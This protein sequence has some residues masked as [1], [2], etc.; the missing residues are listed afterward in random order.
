MSAAP[1]IAVTVASAAAKALSRDRSSSLRELESTTCSSPTALQ[2]RNMRRLP[3]LFRD[4][5]ASVSGIFSCGRAGELPSGVGVSQIGWSPILIYASA[6][7][8]FNRDMAW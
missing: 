2:P 8:H 6:D 3:I 4:S 1:N 7:R 5:I